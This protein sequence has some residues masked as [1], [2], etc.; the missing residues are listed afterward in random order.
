M[1]IPKC[2][3]EGFYAM[4]ALVPELNAAHRASYDL[5]YQTPIDE[6]ETSDALRVAKL[7]FEKL[8]DQFKEICKQH[9]PSE[10]EAKNCDQGGYL[11]NCRYHLDKTMQLPL[12]NKEVV[13][14][15]PQC[16]VQGYQAIRDFEQTLHASRAA[17][18]NHVQQNKVV[19]IIDYLIS[20]G[21]I[22][23]GPTLSKKAFDAIEGQYPSICKQYAPSE[24]EKKNCDMLDAGSYLSGCKFH[25]HMVGQLPFDH[26]STVYIAPQCTV[27]GYLAINE[28]KQTLKASQDSLYN[29]VYETPI[30]E[31]DDMLQKAQAERMM[32]NEQYP[33]ICKEHAPSEAEA[34]ICDMLDVESY[35]TSCKIHLNNGWQVPSRIIKLAHIIPKCTEEGYKALKDFE[36][37]LKT[38]QYDLYTLITNTIVDEPKL[39]QAQAV[40]LMLEGQYPVI[41][42]QY[43][44]SEDE[45]KICDKLDLGS[46]LSSC[47][48]HL[49]TVGQSSS[50]DEL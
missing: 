8:N 49:N 32:L 25:L 11:S 23:D 21:T 12:H 17:H 36:Q 50:H 6:R 29:R 47:N 5:F 43:A 15:I 41:C 14:I 45:A 28:S 27:Q 4:N 39:H 2:T 33:K 24:A 31:R 22:F 44:T 13:H 46:Y 30:D 26:G 35:L 34:K 3:V 40:H 9:A 20:G 38:S 16:T 48:F 1:I 18:L 42:K 10:A 7:K 37:T 19:E